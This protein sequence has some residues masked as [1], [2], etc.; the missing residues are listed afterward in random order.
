MVLDIEVNT[1]I[2]ILNIICF[3]N[4]KQYLNVFTSNENRI[5]LMDKF[6]EIL[7]F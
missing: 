3:M 5:K 7:D 1:T 6:A 4:Q 2:T